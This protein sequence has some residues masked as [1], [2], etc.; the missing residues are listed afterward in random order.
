MPVPISLSGF[1]ILLLWAI[2]LCPI[3]LLIGQDSYHINN[4]T[5]KQGLPQNS[6]RSLVFD[7]RGFLWMAT[8][9][10]IVRFDGQNFRVINT[11]DHPP[12]KNQ[13]FSHALALNDTSILF[14]D[15]LNGLYL[16]ANDHFATLRQ[17]DVKNP[18][19][20]RILGN[21]P[22]AQ[23]L[24][25]DSFYHE[26]NKR[27]RMTSQM[28]INILPLPDHKVYLVSDRIVVVDLKKHTRQILQEKRNK[29]DKVALLDGELLKLDSTDQLHVLQPA[30]GKFDKCT[31][32]DE[33]G[34]TWHGLTRD[35]RVYSQYPFEDVF[36]NDGEKLFRLLPTTDRKRYV[37][38]TLLTS[39]PENCLIHA[40]A[41]RKSD[42]LLVLG[43][44]SRGVFIYRKKNITTFL[45][46]ETLDKES[47]NYYAQCLLDTS[48]LLATNGMIIDLVT[49]KA[50]GR[51][52]IFFNSFALCRDKKNNIYLNQGL[53][54]VRYNI[55]TKQT[56]QIKADD[57]FSTQACALLDSTI[58]LGTTKGIGYVQNDSVRWV[59]KTSVDKDNYSIKCITRD[60][61]GNLWFGSY[62]QLYRLDART[63][64]VDSFPQF[65]NADCRTLALIRG[66][67]FIG[68]YGS[69][70][71][72]YH[73]D[74]FSRMPNGRNNDL[75][76]THAFVE[77]SNGYLWISTNSGLYKTHLDAVDAYL[78]DTTL[79]LDYYTYREE[80]GIRN[81]EFNGGC[82][83]SYL[84]LPDGRLSLPTIEGLVMFNP[85][86]TPHYFSRD[87]MVFDALEVDGIKYPCDKLLRISPNHAN[88][89]VHFA[90]SWWNQPYNEYV[91]IKI[92]GLH[93]EYQL[94]T[95]GHHL[96]PIGHL[97]P[98]KYTIVIR[99]R[100]GF[101]SSD[102]VYS[103]LTFI[104]LTPWYAKPWAF[105]LYGIGFIFSIWATSVTY[106]RSIRQ[107]NIELQKKVD[108][109]TA[110][111]MNTNK[112]LEENLHKLEASELNLRKNIR[113]RDRLIS[114][115]THDIL[116]PLRF[117]GQIAR[118]GGEDKPGGDGLAKRALT[119][120]QNAVHKLFH[121]TQNLLHWV[122][123]QQEQ[124]KTTSTNCS[125]FALVEQLME[126]FSEMSRFQG[127]ILVNEVPEDDVILTDPRILNI[128]L[129]NLL[130]NAIKYTK[131]G[132]VLVRSRTEENWYVL[133][134]SDSGRGMTLT[135]LEGVRQGTTRQGD[136][137][138]EDISAG[139]GIGLSLVA[140]LMQA[141]HGRWEIDSPEGAG[142]R[143]RIFISLDTT[144]IV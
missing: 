47:N 95:M 112:Q 91:S 8:E 128:V 25:Q 46:E 50:S 140:D 124:F 118:L 71:F 24:I 56:Y 19:M 89:T 10:G 83:P 58:W 27:G 23:F 28:A 60:A 17:P 34:N 135:Q 18:Q 105:I 12:I 29:G 125:P 134:V 75:A 37:M 85:D 110:K 14:I 107:R 48:S 77:D 45:Q 121:S 126:D 4:Y 123:Y 33:S 11:N 3:R 67:V 41:Y 143:V 101:G 20:L 76:N 127:N 90:G 117:I 9:G 1:R 21:P 115:I 106:S 116:T 80:D 100:S 96:F 66:K 43:T 7:T 39:L 70:Y 74:H 73:D 114:I 53:K 54:N 139:T 2:A 108:E 142:V 6:V 36:V 98:G 122:T 97:K 103:R 109:Q 137:S 113:V 32:V 129:H 141:L 42:D 31:L 64:T 13:R 44:N 87:T 119:D 52:P 99:R 131:N 72:I 51:F 69:G 55:D 144:P 62:F 15:L 26:E 40:V 93:E 16:L 130:S 5:S 63:H 132:H 84:W 92:E 59:Y 79:F 111:L 22:D 57:A 133:E 94:C 138:V 136:V 86:K 104:V 35:I 120:V 81:T 38:R 78:Q 102:F 49:N 61:G 65:A 82:S 68:T 88:I 30:T